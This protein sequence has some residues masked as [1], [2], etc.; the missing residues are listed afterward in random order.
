[1]NHLITV[2]QN[3]DAV[4]VLEQAPGQVQA[5]ECMATALGVDDEH[6]VRARRHALTGAHAT[7]SVRW[8]LRA[9]NIG[10]PHGAAAQLLGMHG[11]GS[12]DG[13]KLWISMRDVA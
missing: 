7:D 13:P 8:Q 4:P 1:M 2:I 6:T 10:A 5:E 3:G 11:D 9:E 12:T